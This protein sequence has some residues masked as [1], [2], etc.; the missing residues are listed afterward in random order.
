LRFN[1]HASEV[2]HC[3]GQSSR[4]RGFG[5]GK[6]LIQQFFSIMLFYHLLVAISDDILFCSKVY[7][8]PPMYR[9]CPFWY[10]RNFPQIS[11]SFTSAFRQ[12]VG[13]TFALAS[14]TNPS[15]E[16]DGIHLTED[17]GLRYVNVVPII[18][19]NLI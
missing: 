18:E 8:M 11:A 15:F 19:Y 1:F 9:E 5:A 10:K 16:R 14:Y 12:P 6:Y 3:G 7:L 4:P 17:D 2:F 13:H